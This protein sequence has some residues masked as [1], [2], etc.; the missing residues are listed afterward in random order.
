MSSRRYDNRYQEPRNRLYRNTNDGMIL[1]VC[2]GVADYFGFDRS[3]TRILTVVAGFLFPPA[4]LLTYIVL[5]LLL[6]KAPASSRQT[7]AE[8]YVLRQRVRAEPH[9]TLDSIR[10]RF[11]DLDRRMQRLEKHVTSKRFR[12]EQ[13]FD[14]LKD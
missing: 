9:A 8:R 3:V 7:T 13:E 4:T 14:G 11:R 1:G 5:G 12:L 10:H 2:A 6:E